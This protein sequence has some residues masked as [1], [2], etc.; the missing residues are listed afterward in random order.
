MTILGAGWETCL[1]DAAVGGFNTSPDLERSSA[2]SWDALVNIASLY[3][4]NHDGAYDGQQRS[5]EDFLF[6]LENVLTMSQRQ[7]KSA[8]Q[9]GCF[10]L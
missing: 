9:P 8:T 5:L 10:Q 4:I 7:Q 1:V 6:D 3:N 2:D